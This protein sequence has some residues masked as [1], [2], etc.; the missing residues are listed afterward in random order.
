MSIAAGIVAACATYT[1]ET[2]R[3]LHAVEI[4]T[5]DFTLFCG[6]LPNRASASAA[7]VLGYILFYGVLVRRVSQP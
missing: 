7:H 4:N 5:V 2:G 1:R 6:E 3:K